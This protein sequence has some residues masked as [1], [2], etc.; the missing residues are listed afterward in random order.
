MLTYHAEVGAPLYMRQSVRLVN[1]S[2]D[3][4]TND[5]SEIRFGHPQLLAMKRRLFWIPT[6]LIGMLGWA[7]VGLFWPEV[8]TWAFGQKDLAALVFWL[9]GVP[10]LCRIALNVLCK[11][12]TRGENLTCLMGSRWFSLPLMPSFYINRGLRSGLV[13]VEQQTSSGV[14]Y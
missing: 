11:A 7:L 9:A 14:D 6:I 12:V 13:R 8:T 10:I 1:R 3:S 4:W 2:G 5:A